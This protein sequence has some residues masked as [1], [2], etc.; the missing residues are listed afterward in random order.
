V[1]ARTRPDASVSAASSAYSA[2]LVLSAVVLEQARAFFECRGAE[3]CE[4]TAM[5][6]AGPNGVRLVVPDQRPSRS[7]MGVSVHVTA[8]GQLELAAALGVD[9]LFVSRIH[10]HPGEAFHSPI[11]DR[12]PVLTYRGALS[13]V[14]PYFGLG[15]RR[16]LLACAVLRHD[17]QRWCDLPPGPGRDLWVIAEDTNSGERTP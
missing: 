5:I 15:L 4:G 6:A 16:G 7:P 14:V 12:N 9:E 10:S 1:I 2:P 13:V 11:D 3:G 8:Q 17:G